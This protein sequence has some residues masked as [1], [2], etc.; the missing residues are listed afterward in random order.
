MKITTSNLI[1]WGGFSAMVAGI[2]Y[3]A[4]RPHSIAGPSPPSPSK[5]PDRPNHHI[6]HYM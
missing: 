4:A 2:M 5:P 6:N 3:A 1:R